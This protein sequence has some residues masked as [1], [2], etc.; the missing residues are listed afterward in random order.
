M[1]GRFNILKEVVLLASSRDSSNGPDWSDIQSTM[2]ELEV[3]WCGRITMEFENSLVGGRKQLRATLMMHP[4]NVNLLDQRKSVSLSL[5]LDRSGCG[6]G[7][8]AIYRGLLAL[9]YA[10]SKEWAVKQK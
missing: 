5:T 1:L 10:I 6:L 7:V 2:Q 8:A 4:W 3:E 9:D